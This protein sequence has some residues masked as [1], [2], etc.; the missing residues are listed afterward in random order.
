MSTS[1]E[2]REHKH[3]IHGKQPTKV[4]RLLSYCLSKNNY[5]ASKNQYAYL[6][7]PLVHILVKYVYI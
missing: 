4:R 5:G 7:N 1:N 2:E 3:S 6:M